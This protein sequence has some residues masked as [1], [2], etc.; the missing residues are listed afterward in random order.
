MTIDAK[1]NPNEIWSMIFIAFSFQFLLK[2]TPGPVSNIIM[3]D[4]V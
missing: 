3:A 1:Q 4:T 2:L